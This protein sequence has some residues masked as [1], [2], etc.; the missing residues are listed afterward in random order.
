MKTE[1]ENKNKTKNKQDLTRKRSFRTN[2]RSSVCEGRIDRAQRGGDLS[3]RWKLRCHWLAAAGSHLTG[4]EDEEFGGS[5]WRRMK[6]ESRGRGRERV[7]KSMFRKV[8]KRSH[9]S[10]VGWG[11]GGK[12]WRRRRWWWGVGSFPV[13]ARCPRS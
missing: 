7:L 4:G 9:G 6:D 13:L 5:R 1:Q 12:G 8:G 10:R 11:R 3:V 2:G